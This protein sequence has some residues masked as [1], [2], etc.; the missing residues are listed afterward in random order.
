MM[1]K[2][3]RTFQI[4]GIGSDTPEGGIAEDKCPFTC[5]SGYVKDESGRACK[6]PSQGK[7]ADA[8]GA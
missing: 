8:Q 7:Y 6:L 1:R 5:K 4:R 2:P 3:A